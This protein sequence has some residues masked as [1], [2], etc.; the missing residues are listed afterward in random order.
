VRFED[1]TSNRSGTISEVCEFLGV[2]ESVSELDEEGANRGDTRAVAKGLWIGV[3]SSSWYRNGVRKLMPTNLRNKM[4]DAILAKPE[5]RKIA[6][7]L[8][9]IEFL[10]ESLQEDADELAKILDW[11]TPIWDFD[12][13]RTKYNAHSGETL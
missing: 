5:L 11:P 13:T 9:T 4:R 6:P 8:Q 3:L 1:Y 2:P 12:K 10:I 7:S